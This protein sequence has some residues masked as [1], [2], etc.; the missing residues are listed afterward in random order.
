MTISSWYPQLDQYDCIR[1][2]IHL[3]SGSDD[4]SLSRERLLIIDFYF[5]NPPLL[6]HVRMKDSVR[7]KFSSLNVPK[8]ENGFIKYPAPILL[9]RKM[10]P[11]QAQA[12]RAMMGR[13]LIADLDASTSALRLSG[14]GVALLNR[15]LP[16][17]SSS[18]Q[19]LRDFLIEDFSR[20][21][22]EGLGG[23]RKRT[24]LRVIQSVSAS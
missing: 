20:M 19:R 13:G 24:G 22:A 12:I 2:L 15:H 18:E 11:I 17:L 10:Q 16:A 21:D 7:K 23:L 1:R 8:P 3:L 9:F 14:Q 6:H 5:A 4:V